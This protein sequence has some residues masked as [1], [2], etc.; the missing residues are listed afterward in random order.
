MATTLTEEDKDR[1]F[2]I[3]GVPKELANDVDALAAAEDRSRAWMLR[4]LLE[5]IVAQKKAA[6]AAAKKTPASA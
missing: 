1:Q 3:P 2:V 5:E 4:K 6:A